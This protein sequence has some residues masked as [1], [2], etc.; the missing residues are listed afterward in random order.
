MNFKCIFS[1]N[2][3]N[4]I[5]TYISP[6]RLQ[7]CTTKSVAFSCWLIYYN[8]LYWISS[9]DWNQMG[10]D[11]TINRNPGNTLTVYRFD[12]LFPFNWPI[13]TRWNLEFQF[14]CF[15][16]SLLFQVTTTLSHVN[17]RSL[18]EWITLCGSKFHGLTIA[19][20]VK[21]STIFLLFSLTKMAKRKFSWNS[22]NKR[23]NNNKN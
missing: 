5:Y 22:K 14:D 2:V 10:E 18:D 6:N 19:H 11:V 7:L 1:I 17:L 12:R 3:Q 9:S 13:E 21:I 15:Y 8:D 23:K 16:Y 20:K 4:K